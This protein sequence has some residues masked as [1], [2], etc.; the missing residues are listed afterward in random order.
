MEERT[1]IKS[2][3]KNWWK[4]KTKIN[5]SVIIVKDD[6]LG[7]NFSVNK[8]VFHFFL[9]VCNLHQL[10]LLVSSAFWSSGELM[11]PRKAHWRKQH[12][13]EALSRP[14]CALQENNRILKT[15]CYCCI[16]ATGENCIW[17]LPLHA[18]FDKKWLL[19]LQVSF[20]CLLKPSSAVLLQLMILQC[21]P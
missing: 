17:P 6:S 9:W 13:L 10:L 12:L 2:L 5:H 18:D 3:G 1:S 7:I 8:P 11:L 14:Y 16:K 20:I 21:F 4:L 19:S 15:N